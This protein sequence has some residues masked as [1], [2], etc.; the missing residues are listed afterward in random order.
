MDSKEKNKSD[1]SKNLIRL[2]KERGLS[3]MKLAKLAGLTQRM[4]AYYEN[5]AVKPPLDNIVAIAK[6]LGVNINTLLGIS[7]SETSKTLLA[8]LDSRTITKLK[9]ILS[10]PKKERHIIYSIAENF[11]AKRELKKLKQSYECNLVD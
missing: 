5:E 8:K 9:L 10:L 11:H 2:R 1:F 7:E 3:Q 6:A 4:I